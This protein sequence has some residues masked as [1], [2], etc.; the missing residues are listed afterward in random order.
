[1][2]KKISFTYKSIGN[3]CHLLLNIQYEKTHSPREITVFHQR[4]D[5]DKTDN[6]IEE[7][8]IKLFPNGVTIGEKEIIQLTSYIENFMLQDK[9]TQDLFVKYD[10][11]CY[12]HYVYFKPDNIV[13]ECGFAE[14]SE[15]VRNIC[16]DFFKGFTN[17]DLN[18]EYI[19]TF[20]KEN[21]EIK[22][23]NS[24]IEQIANDNAYIMSCINIQNLRSTKNA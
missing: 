22:S 20:I 3:L 23:D 4:F 21:F 19:K 9:A 15:K 8:L 24:T 14:H 17:E 6:L 7:I 12:P 10:K 18:C 13:Y 11:R 16:C 5:N 2:S 1:M